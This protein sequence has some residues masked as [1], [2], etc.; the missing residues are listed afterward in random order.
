MKDPARGGTRDQKRK[1]KVENETKET[2]AP[3][4][5]FVYSKGFWVKNAAG[6]RTAPCEMFM[7]GEPEFKI[8]FNI[9]LL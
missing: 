7:T 9:L 5:A 4:A 8:N 6:T 1:N 2:E 3:A